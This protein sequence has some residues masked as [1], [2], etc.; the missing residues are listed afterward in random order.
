MC[1]GDKRRLDRSDSY[2]VAISV[3]P[4]LSALVDQAKSLQPSFALVSTGE[5]K[6]SLWREALPFPLRASHDVDIY[7]I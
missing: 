3:V 5:K 2:A 7:V 6:P 4:P 1:D